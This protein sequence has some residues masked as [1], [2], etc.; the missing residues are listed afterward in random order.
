MF[1]VKR[2][3]LLHVNFSIIKYIVR[4]MFYKKINVLPPF[5]SLLTIFTCNSG[6]IP[7]ICLGSGAQ[8]IKSTK[9]VPNFIPKNF[10]TSIFC[11]STEFSPWIAKIFLSGCS[12]GT[13]L[14]LESTTDPEKL[15]ERGQ[16]KR[17]SFQHILLIKTHGGTIF[18]WI[19]EKRRMG[20]G[21][22]ND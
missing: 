7:L 8:W 11:E 14:F 9:V 17:Q 4:H 21:G 3:T 18:F 12:V 2:F 22:K 19:R 1:A 20:A 13:T 15:L 6:K 5:H 16:L 10:T